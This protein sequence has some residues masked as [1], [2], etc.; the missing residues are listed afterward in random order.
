VPGAANDR[1][2]TGLVIS[3]VAYLINA[4]I[5]TWYAIANDIP[6]RPLGIQTGLSVALDF[7]VGLGSGLS[8]PLV[9]LIALG[10]LAVSVIRH[11]GRRP[12]LWMGLLGGCFLVGM[13][14]EPIVGQ[15]MDGEHE[16]LAI[17]IILAN[18]ILPIM[19]IGMAIASARHAREGSTPQGVGIGDV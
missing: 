11:G 3:S 1:A 16:P 14:I 2:K 17:G 9:M 7:T 8:A 12:I 6:G 18:V 5:G 4:A 15:A 19:M 10:F 13:L